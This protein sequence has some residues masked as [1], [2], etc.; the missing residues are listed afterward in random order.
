VN[1]AKDLSSEGWIERYP[2]QTLNKN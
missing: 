2:T 1:F